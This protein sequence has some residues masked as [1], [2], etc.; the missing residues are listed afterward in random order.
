MPNPRKRNYFSKVFKNENELTDVISVVIF[1]VD[2]KTYLI[3]HD[4]NLDYH[5][6]YVPVSKFSWKI[7]V[8][9]FVKEVS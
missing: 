5:I 3:A 7:Q 4:Y 6:P 8:Q 9:D 1:C 2:D